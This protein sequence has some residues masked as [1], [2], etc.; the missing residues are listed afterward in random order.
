MQRRK[1][2]LC[3]CHDAIMLRVRQMLLEHFG[4]KVWPTESVEDA[5]AI[6]VDSCPDMLLMDNSYPGVNLEQLAER[7][8]KDCPG[9]LAVVLSPLFAV[10]GSTQ[11]AVDCFLAQNDGPDALRAN[12]EELFAAQ[13][14]GDTAT[15]AVML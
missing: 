1:A 12:L 6:R 3:L 14:D 11:T 8:K 15:S 2:I 7:I 4:Y 13:G 5:A 9:M 10:R